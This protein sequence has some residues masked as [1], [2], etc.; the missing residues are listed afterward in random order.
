MEIPFY[1]V[2]TSSTALLFVIKILVLNYR[3]FTKRLRRKKCTIG[4]WKH[5]AAVQAQIISLCSWQSFGYSIKKIKLFI[6]G[7]EG[8]D[9]EFLLRWFW[10]RELG[11]NDRSGGDWVR[12][13]GNKE[14]VEFDRPISSPFLRVRRSDS[15]LVAKKTQWSP[16]SHGNDKRSF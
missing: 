8:A 11:F 5:F 12:K 14:G 7:R 6:I 3:T 13:S 9:T 1:R 15:P 10:T 16:Q 4:K 2:D